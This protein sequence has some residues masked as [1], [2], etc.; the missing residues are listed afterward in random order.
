MAGATGVPCQVRFED[1]ATGNLIDQRNVT[2]NGAGS[3]GTATVPTFAQGNVKVIVK[4]WHWLSKSFSRTLTA[5]GTATAS[6]TYI[7]GDI[8]GDDEV[9]VLDYITLSATFGTEAGQLG[10]DVDADLDGDSVVS[11]LDYLILSKNYGT[12][13]A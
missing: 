12:S 7:N 2:L 13:G 11:I 3:V 8:D 5:H 9:S 6:G 10:F 1:L 4:P